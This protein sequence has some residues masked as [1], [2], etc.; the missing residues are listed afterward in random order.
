MARALPLRLQRSPHVLAWAVAAWLGTSAV[1]LGAPERALA[2]EVSQL[3]AERALRRELQTALRVRWD[4]ETGTPERVELL[5]PLALAAAGPREAAWEFLA[6]LEPLYGAGVLSP[7]ED[8][9]SRPNPHPNLHPYLHLVSTRRLGERVAVDF[10]QR[11]GELTVHGAQLRV[12]LGRR[13]DQALGLGLSGRIYR[14]LPRSL[15]RLGAP[16]APAGEGLRLDGVSFSGTAPRVVL[17][18]RGGWQVARWS[19][20]LRAGQPRELLRDAEGALLLERP[21]GAG[22]HVEAQVV[23]RDPG[24]ARARRGLA[25]LLVHG[26]DGRLHTSGSQ[27]R[28]GAP[29]GALLGGLLG[30]FEGVAAR[31]GSYPSGAVI[32]L[33]ASHEQEAT[34]YFHLRKTRLWFERFRGQI[35]GVEASARARTLALTNPARGGAWALP[36]PSEVGGQSYDYTLALGSFGTRSTA[37]DPAVITHERVHSLL[38]GFGFT[39]LRGLSS[40][41]HEGLADYFAAVIQGE[42]RVGRYSIGVFA[43]DLSELRRWPEHAAEEPQTTGRIFSGALLDARDALGEAVDRVVLAAAGGFT[44]ATDFFAARDQI[45]SLASRYGLSRAQL[46]PHFARHGL[47]DPE[48]G[49]RA[50]LIQARV[51]KEGTVENGHEL[52]SYRASEEVM[53]EFQATSPDE[54][55]VTLLVSGL[56]GLADEVPSSGEGVRTFQTRAPAAP[57]IYLVSVHASDERQLSST[58][59]TQ[60]WVREDERLTSSRGALELRAPTGETVGFGPRELATAISPDLDPE[61][62]TWRLSGRAALGVELDPSGLRLTAQPGEEGRYTLILKGTP[63]VVSL[64]E[65]Y[66]LEVHVEAGT[67]PDFLL[68]DALAPSETQQAQAALA[69][70]W[71]GSELSVRA[72]SALEL[73]LRGVGPEHTG[74]L[75][76]SLAD[77]ASSVARLLAGG[78]LSG[79]VRARGLLL[80]APPADHPVATLELAVL[81]REGQR[82]LARRA[83]KVH[84]IPRGADAPPEIVAPRSVSLEGD[85]GQFE[86]QVRDPEGQAVQ[87]EVAWPLPGVQPSAGEV[88]LQAQISEAPAGSPVTYRIVVQRLQPGPFTIYLRATDS[89]GGR[90]LRAVQVGAPLE[91]SAPRDGLK[92]ALERK[93]GAG[94]E[95]ERAGAEGRAPARPDSDWAE[96]AESDG[97][98]W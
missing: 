76:V 67:G 27:G 59:T 4:G 10:E 73:H 82:V 41:L 37:L 63:R 20:E 2:P 79:E 89:A 49:A 56:E 96:S 34:A 15:A 24:Q 21:W 40:A 36:S 35:P 31:H 47:G 74:A 16:A 61:D 68:V 22:A 7:R 94:G 93:S 91:P 46:L 13:G 57:G 8:G 92:Q 39:E 62:V 77:E 23:L 12:L 70:L 95:P 42:R 72:G 87:L 9:A 60:V 3:V 38:Y 14:D 84:V 43:R 53:F 33:G 17:T 11:C 5:R 75:E 66:Q 85:Q 18:P 30:R 52:I 32:A 6:H 55:R 29:S 83:L 90:T 81:Y 78:E 45:F 86:A 50:P 44:G 58:L 69:P 48:E 25:D 1:G 51:Y 71:P 98:D 26:S 19:V 64:L 97:S 28:F 88:H 54:Q 80:I 65:V